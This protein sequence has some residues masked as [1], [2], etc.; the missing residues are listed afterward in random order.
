[1]VIATLTLTTKLWNVKPANSYFLWEPTIKYV[2]MS[3]NPTE[4][5]A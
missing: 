4:M 1:M 3:F 2:V 5:F